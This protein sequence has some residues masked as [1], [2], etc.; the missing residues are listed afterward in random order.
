MLWLEPWA[1]IYIHSGSKLSLYILKREWIIINNHDSTEGYTLAFSPWRS[2]L[3]IRR[4]D[5]NPE[6]F[7][8]KIPPCIQFSIY[9]RLFRH[10]SIFAGGIPWCLIRK[11][12]GNIS[13]VHA[14]HCDGTSFK[15]MPFLISGPPKYFFQLFVEVHWV[16]SAFW[17]SWIEPIMIIWYIRSPVCMY[18]QKHIMILH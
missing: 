8:F 5:R 16:H 12:R 10:G 7:R 15:M 18:S 11:G 17:V 2:G 13:W 3:V 6:G 14:C 4:S 9:V 1:F